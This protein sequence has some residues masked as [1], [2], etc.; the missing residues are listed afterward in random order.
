M[1]SRLLKSQGRYCDRVLEHVLADPLDDQLTLVWGGE[2]PRNSKPEIRTTAVRHG[3]GPIL[4]VRWSCK[5]GA[6]YTVNEYRLVATFLE[7]AP[8]EYQA[9]FDLRFGM[10]L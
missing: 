2:R 6:D 5:C 1:C 8:D 10:E 9:T 7:H 4:A 3:L